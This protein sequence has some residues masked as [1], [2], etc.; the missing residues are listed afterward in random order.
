M[1][2]DEAVVRLEDGMC[3]A[4]SDAYTHARVDVEVGSDGVCI[5]GMV[6]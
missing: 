2:Y 3:C 5:S 6:E 1:R 4:A